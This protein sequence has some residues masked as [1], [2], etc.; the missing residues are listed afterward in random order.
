MRRRMKLPAVAA[1]A[2]VVS[3]LLNG[4]AMKQGL[5]SIN[6]TPRVFLGTRVFHSLWLVTTKE[7]QQRTP[8][9]RVIMPQDLINIIIWMA[10]T[11]L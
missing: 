11:P 9:P 4:R 2:A 6:S 3:E 5:G 8:P 10:M 1:R 7:L